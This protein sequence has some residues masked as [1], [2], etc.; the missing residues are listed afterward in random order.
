MSMTEDGP[1]A[2]VFQ[3]L[4]VN[5]LFAEIHLFIV[6]VSY[7]EVSRLG[8]QNGPVGVAESA[9]AVS[10]DPGYMRSRPCLEFS[11]ISRI[12]AAVDDYVHRGFFVK[13]LENFDDPRAVSVSI[14]YH[15]YFHISMSFFRIFACFHTV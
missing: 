6:T 11:G 5:V 12:V 13:L 3:S 4:V 9:V 8:F 14:A 10:L 7:N 15:Q 2:V 1:D